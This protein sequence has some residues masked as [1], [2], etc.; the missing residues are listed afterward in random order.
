MVNKH[1]LVIFMRCCAWLQVH[2][3]EM[4]ALQ[5]TCFQVMDITQM[6]LQRADAHP[7]QAV[8]SWLPQARA[9]DCSHWCLTGSLDPW[10]S[11]FFLKLQQADLRRAA[12]RCAG[13]AKP[14]CSRESAARDG[15]Q[16]LNG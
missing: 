14:A 7:G 11:L 3:A 4:E 1:G 12:A 5:H 9:S 13:A 8:R 6:T 16:P 15:H 10:L 2:A